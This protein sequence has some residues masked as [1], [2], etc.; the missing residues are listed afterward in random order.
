MSTFSDHDAPYIVT[1]IPK[2]KFQ[3]R[4]KYIR[5]MKHFNIKDY[6]D[7]FKTLPLAVVHSFEDPNENKIQ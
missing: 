3:T 7:D 4:T 5:D 1:N 6:M 2:I